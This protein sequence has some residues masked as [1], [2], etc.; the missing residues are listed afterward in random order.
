MIQSIDHL[1]DNLQQLEAQDEQYKDEFEADTPAA[2]PLPDE[3]THA[4]LEQ[5]LQT[6][7]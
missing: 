6:V 3:A 7:S 4:E 2:V 1:L 5:R